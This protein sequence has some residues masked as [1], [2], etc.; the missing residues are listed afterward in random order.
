MRTISLHTLAVGLAAVVVTGLL[1]AAPSSAAAPAPQ[2]ERI[3]AAAKYGRDA[4]A[5]TNNRRARYDRRVFRSDACLQRYAVRNARRMANREVMRHQQMGPI[6]RACGLNAVGENIA[7]NYPNGRS[8]V[9]GW[10]GSPPHRRNILNPTFRL[11]AVAAR[12]GDN[13]HW[14]AAQVFGRR[15]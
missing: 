10:M 4:F 8:V 9:Q 12:K 14:Y 15:A 13:G 11:M 2:S 7:D 5:A 1:A 3:S 6:M